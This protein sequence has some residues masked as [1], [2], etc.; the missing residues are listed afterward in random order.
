VQSSFLLPEDGADFR[1]LPGEYILRV[2]AKRVFDQAPQE[3][4][5]ITLFL[6]ESHAQQLSQEGTGIYFDWG[7][8]QKNIILSSTSTR[9]NR[10]FRMYCTPRANKMRTSV[11]LDERLEA[12][13]QRAVELVQESQA[14]VIR[15]AIRTG[16]PLIK[17]LFQTPRPEGYFAEAYQKLSHERVKT[18]TGFAKRDKVSPDR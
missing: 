3:L 1:F 15:L 9:T 5:Q 6:S 4:S 13:L 17:Y 18:E 7:P 10:H 2:F 12:D 16:L 11:G 8:D 14:T